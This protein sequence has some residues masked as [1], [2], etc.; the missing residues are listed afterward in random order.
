MMP[1]SEKNQPVIAWYAVYT[2]ARHE[3]VVAEELWRRKIECFLP[4]HERVSWWK[5]RR[6]VVQFPLFPGYVF[7]HTQVALRRIDILRVSSV[8][9]ILGS[10]GRP[11]AIPEGQIQ[12]VKTLVFKEI[13]LDPHPF[14]QEGD[15]VRVTRGPLRG[16]EG[17]L[18]EKKNR[19][20][21][22]L[23]VDLIGQSVACEIDAEDVEKL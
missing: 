19:Y 17:F 11:E 16:L 3:K 4:L 14:S 13:P 10:Q 1:V 12:A 22:V 6:Q 9:R 7:V 23:S 8:V 5:D 20:T 15:R 2:R 18:S 21:F